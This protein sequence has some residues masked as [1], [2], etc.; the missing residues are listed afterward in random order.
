[1]ISCFQGFVIPELNSTGTS[2]ESAQP[3]EQSYQDPEATRPKVTQ[4]KA[5]QATS[6]GLLDF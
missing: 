6:S 2:M 3:N 5:P 4:P 1:M